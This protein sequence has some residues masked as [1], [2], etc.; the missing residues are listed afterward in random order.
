MHVCL[1]VQMYIHLCFCMQYHAIYVGYVSTSYERIPRYTYVLYILCVFLDTEKKTYV[2]DSLKTMICSYLKKI[3]YP[4]DE[5][6]STGHEIHFPS[7]RNTFLQR[8]RA[9]L[10]WS[11][12]SVRGWKI[13]PFTTDKQRLGII[14]EII[15]FKSSMD[16]YGWLGDDHNI[17]PFHSSRS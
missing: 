1:Y 15:S 7:P 13:L 9:S 11:W 6:A 8:L 10:R 16:Q 4:H 12:W 17:H 14:R 2:D 5:S 3:P